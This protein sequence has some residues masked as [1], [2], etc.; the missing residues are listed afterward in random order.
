M[1]VLLIA[2]LSSAGA[3]LA[4]QVAS[5]PPGPQTAASPG[6]R[7]PSGAGIL[8][9]HV[10]TDRTAEFERVLARI[11]EVLDATA[12]PARRQQATSWR[13]F[14]SLEEQPGDT[15]YLFFFD[16]AVASA[17][18]DPVRLLG[19]ALPAESQT[20]YE[21]LKRSVIRVERMGL[22]KIR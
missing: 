10:H 5:A 3:T 16:P 2:A 13:I 12:D 4:P 14:R 8:Y 9:F 1:V 21:S 18:Y 11:G 22:L 17:D 20:L 19:E 7:F 6:Y 15:I